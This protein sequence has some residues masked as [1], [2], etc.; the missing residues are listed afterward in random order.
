MAQPYAAAGI[1]PPLEELL[2]DQIAHLVMRRDGTG[3]AEVWRSVHEARARWPH[4]AAA[5]DAPEPPGRGAAARPE[6]GD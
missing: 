5:A 4:I 1:E 6:I 2:D 3:P